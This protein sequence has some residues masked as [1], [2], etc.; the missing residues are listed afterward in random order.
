MS[1]MWFWVAGGHMQQDQLQG[2]GHGPPSS[3]WIFTSIMPVNSEPNPVVLGSLKTCSL[4]QLYPSLHLFRFWTHNAAL[5]Y[6]TPE[7]N[8]CF[9]PLW[10]AT[11]EWKT[12][13]ISQQTRWPSELLSALHTTLHIAQTTIGSFTE[14]DPCLWKRKLFRLAFFSF[15]RDIG[16]VVE[17]LY[18]DAPP[19]I[20]MIGHSM[21]GAIAVHTAAANH[22]PSLLGLCVID[23][24]EGEAGPFHPNKPT[25]R[26]HSQPNDWWH[27]WTRC[28][29]CIQARRWMLWT[30]CR[31]SSEVDQSRSSLWRM[32][33]SGG[34]W[35]NFQFINFNIFGNCRGWVF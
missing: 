20:M 8:V 14:Q 3:W 7:C 13:T 2:G 30:A 25:T 18:G 26:S 23:V 22:V 24:V 34:N 33:L 19:P 17:A 1:P 28:N 9:F 12:R 32:P 4:L 31:T 35:E 15:Q 5:S 29:I 16:K 27:Q 10:Q 6:M 21:G 11:P